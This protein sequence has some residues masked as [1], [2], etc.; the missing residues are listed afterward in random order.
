MLRPL[1]FS[2]ALCIALLLCC[3]CTDKDHSTSI[4][5]STADTTT[6]PVTIPAITDTTTTTT[7]SQPADTEPQNPV[8]T[9]AAEHT[10][11]ISTTTTYVSTERFPVNPQ[12]GEHEWDPHPLHFF[13]RFH[14][15]GIN[16]RL[17]GG[18]YQTLHYPLTEAQT[19]ALKDTYIIQ[20]CNFDGHY[21]LLLPLSNEEQ[22]RLFAIFLWDP[23]T[24]RYLDHCIEITSPVF[25]A[26]RSEVR[27]SLGSG[28]NE[29]SF[30]IF[31][32]HQQQLLPAV[33]FLANREHL[34]ITI[35]RYELGTLLNTEVL[36][37]PTESDWNAA[38]N[39]FWA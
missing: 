14:T 35:I 10:L 25:D 3:A 32:W 33:Q 1:R 17:A 36:R 7:Q 29:I 8:T 30:Q 4:Q 12:Y 38:I 13:Y 20:D 34:T 11:P 16:L 28:T 39:A 24:M 18:S 27:C 37:Y 2:A 9:T 19:T 26:A 15:D 22:N 23:D 31:L 5:S 21:D 6:A